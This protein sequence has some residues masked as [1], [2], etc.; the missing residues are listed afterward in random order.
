[1][2]WDLWL[3]CESISRPTLEIAVPAFTMAAV[4]WVLYISLDGTI[5]C[6]S[7]VG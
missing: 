7:P 5:C 4:Y 1:M 2:V 3:K 6:L